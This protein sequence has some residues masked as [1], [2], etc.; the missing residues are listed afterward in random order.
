M[1]IIRIPAYELLLSSLRSLRQQCGRYCSRNMWIV[2]IYKDC[3]Y[4]RLT[5]I[6][7]LWNYKCFMQKVPWAPA[8]QLLSFLQ[9]KCHSVVKACSTH[10]I[11][12]A[13][14]TTPVMLREVNE[15]ATSI[16]HKCVGWSYWCLFVRT[17]PA[18]AL[19]GRPEIPNLYQDSLNDFSG[20]CSCTYPP[21]YVV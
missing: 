21:S 16:C 1:K 14:L 3:S 9:M 20:H 7:S 10:K 19:R 11:L 5:I 6:R 18:T 17:S 2:T 4:C 8:F 13:G 15:Y 12:M